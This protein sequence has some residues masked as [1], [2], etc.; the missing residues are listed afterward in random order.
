VAKRITLCLSTPNPTANP[1]AGG[2][3]VQ[4][5]N[6]EGQRAPEACLVSVRPRLLPISHAAQ[7]LVRIETDQAGSLRR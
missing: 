1:F 5:R 4:Q 6:G 7:P 2:S 3:R